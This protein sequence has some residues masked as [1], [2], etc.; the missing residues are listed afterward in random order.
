MGR[1]EICGGIASGKTTLAKCLEGKNFHVIYER[2]Q[3]NPFLNEFYTQGGLDSTFET[4]LVFVLLHYNLIKTNNI[5]LDSVCDY[6][7]LQDYSYGISNLKNEDMIQF[8][9]LYKY[10]SNE[11]GKADM[12]IYLKCEV[13]VLLER[14][15]QRDRKMEQ[16]ITGEYLQ[17]TID[18]LENNLKNQSNVLVIESDKYNFLN[19]D[20]KYVIDKIMNFWDMIA[21]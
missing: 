12:I 8:E 20:K 9:K 10:L 7:L 2:F 13:N 19:K 18:A 16:G 15:W 1:I 14:I 21:K 11:I 17:R 4:E 5:L 6:S 3:D